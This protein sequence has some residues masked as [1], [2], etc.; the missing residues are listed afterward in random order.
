MDRTPIL[1]QL[2]R[3][4]HAAASKP[5]WDALDGFERQLQQQLPLLAKQGPLSDS[6]QAAMNTL[7]RL[8]AQVLEMCANEKQRLGLQLGEIHS[9]QD[10]WVAY[11][12]ENDMYQ[13]ENQA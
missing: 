6:E 5:D 12:I 4:L 9:K 10:G 1:R 8:H 7:R 11:A 3:D 13:D 2:S